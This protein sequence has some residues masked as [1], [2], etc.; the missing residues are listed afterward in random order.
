[1]KE[2]K[3][4]VK[5]IVTIAAIGTCAYIIGLCVINIWIWSVKDDKKRQAKEDAFKQAAHEYVQEKN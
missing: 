5:L 1:M 3:V 2:K 4:P